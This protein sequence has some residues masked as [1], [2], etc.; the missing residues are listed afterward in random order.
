MK[1]ILSIILALFTILAF[2]EN[3]KGIY[4]N[5]IGLASF[6]LLLKIN[7]AF[8]HEEIEEQTKH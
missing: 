7:N 3:F 5:F 6:F 8:N 2:N 4:L 1:K